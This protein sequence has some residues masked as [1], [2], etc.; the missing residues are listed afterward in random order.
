M[1]SELSSLRLVAYYR[2]STE[3]DER[4]VHSIGDQRRWAQSFVQREG[5]SL[6]AEIEEQ[7]SAKAPGRAGFAE[8]LRVVDCGAADALLAWDPSRLARNVI[9][10][11]QIIY[12][13]DTGGLRAV[14][15]SAGV[16]RP[17]SQDKLTLGVM[18]SLSKNYVDN[19]REVTLRG[20]RSRAQDGLWIT[21]P[22]YGC[23]KGETRGIPVADPERWPWVEWIFEQAAAGLGVSAIT[24]QLVE[25]GA[26]APPAGGRWSTSTV[27]RIIHSRFYVG[28]IL[29]DGEIYTAR[30]QCRVEPRLWQLA[31]QPRA[32]L[33][34][35]KAGGYVYLLPRVEAA[36]LSIAEPRARAGEP[37]PYYGTWTQGRGGRRYHYYWL[38]SRL[39]LASRGVQL[40]QASLGALPQAIPA[41]D[42][43]GAV[44]R[45]LSRLAAKGDLPWLRREWRAASEA[46]LQEARSTLASVRKRQ[47]RLQREQQRYEDLLA[48]AFEV[49]IKELLDALARKLREA[50]AK[51]ESSAAE[52]AAVEARLAALEQSGADAGERSRWV[53]LLP[54]LERQGRRA[55][56][57]ELLALLIERVIVTGR[58]SAQVVFTTPPVVRQRNRKA[59]LAQRA[60]NPLREYH[61]GLIQGL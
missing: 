14:A 31:Q 19:L 59:A 34:R 26:P 27:D 57:R 29:V 51:L 13:L 5:L 17:T 54:L 11:A 30:H 53:E 56:L 12:R 60:K 40:A 37:C 7:R 3:Q 36:G 43:E 44:L 10:S 8:A 38:A 46:S 22:P 33:P 16:F 61:S 58:N 35:P 15:T 21:K 9:D 39:N 28:E 6:V 52:M 42:L 49:G 23:L 25:L 32:S 18:F 24:R 20:M 4:Q 55:E 41:G 47:A 1:A 2:K 48:R 50:R 45:L